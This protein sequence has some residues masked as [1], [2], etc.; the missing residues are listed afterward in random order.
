VAAQEEAGVGE[1]QGSDSEDTTAQAPAAAAPGADEAA[2]NKE[3]VSAGEEQ[4]QQAVA[5]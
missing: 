5:D 1:A 3:G 4:E 2:G